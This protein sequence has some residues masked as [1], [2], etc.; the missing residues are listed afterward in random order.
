[1]QGSFTTSI[2]RAQS[3][4]G[5]DGW[6]PLADRRS[7]CPRP[8]QP[9]GI[10][11]AIWGEGR[12]R[13]FALPDDKP[14]TCVSYVGSP[15]IEVFLEPVAVG[16]SLPEM[17]LF[18]TPE[19]YVPLPLD[20]TYR[21]TWDAF[22]AVWQSVLAAAAAPVAASRKT[23]RLVG[24]KCHQRTPGTTRRRRCAAATRRENQSK[25]QRISRQAAMRQTR[26][27]TNG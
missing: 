9:F 16:D 10:L 23:G 19:L 12:E 15:C 22:P 1:M 25:N 18:L 2:T 8:A 11:R 7:V 5:I 26:K 24:E 17:P 20:A 6:C 13:D 4:S 3:R 14:L 27:D 21:A